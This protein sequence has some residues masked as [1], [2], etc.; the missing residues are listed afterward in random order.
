MSDVRRHVID[1]YNN[2]WEPSG[3]SDYLT[4]S[5]HTVESMIALMNGESR[6]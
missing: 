2:A 3:T 4:G 1:A 5:E 6:T